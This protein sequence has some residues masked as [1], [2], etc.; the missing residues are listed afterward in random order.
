MLPMIPILSGIIVGQGHPT[1]RRQAFTLSLVYVLAMAMTYTLA[2][3]AAGLAG[4]MLSIYL[5]NPWVMGSFAVVFVLLSLSMFGF[6][7]LQLPSSIQSRLTSTLNRSAGGQLFGV[8][9]MGVL[10]AVIV[11]PV[12]PRHWRARCFISARRVT[13]S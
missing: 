13:L 9:I 4:T 3:V 1:S 2:G 11:G 5:Q 7:Q 6:Y 8:F 12:S 10:S